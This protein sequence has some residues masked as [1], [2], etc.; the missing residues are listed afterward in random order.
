MLFQSK[1]KILS[2]S[3]AKIVRQGWLQDSE[4]VAFTNGCFDIL[5]LGHANYLEKAAN[6][7]TKLV[8]GINNDESI[9]SL[10]GKSRPINSLK[11]RMGLL[12][13]LACVS[14]VVP[15][16]ESTPLELIKIIKPDILV[17]G[18]DYSLETIVGAKEMLGWGGQIKQTP[19]LPGYSTTQ[20][21]QKCQ[22]I[23]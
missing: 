6:L 12:A 11:S 22:S 1:Q 8:V 18:E 13:A 2:C 20:I 3:E 14:I 5:H 21:I 9:R 17:K 4:V 7:G 15:F 16:S 23:I 19:L 10:K